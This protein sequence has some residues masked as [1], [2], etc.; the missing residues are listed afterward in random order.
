M[1]STWETFTYRLYKNCRHNFSDPFLRIEIL[2]N[3]SINIVLSNCKAYVA[4][5]KTDFNFLA[6]VQQIEKVTTELKLM[7]VSNLSKLVPVIPIRMS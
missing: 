4:F 5:Y 6:W 2:S 3:L 7:L 1:T